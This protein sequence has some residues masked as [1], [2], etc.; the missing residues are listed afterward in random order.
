MTREVGPVVFSKAGQ[1]GGEVSHDLLISKT[2][3][4]R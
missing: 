1:G 2:D 3:K 4:I